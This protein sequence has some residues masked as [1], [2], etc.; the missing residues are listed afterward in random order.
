MFCIY[1]FCIE[2]LTYSAAHKHS[3]TERGKR[4]KEWQQEQTLWDDGW[5]ES[6]GTRTK[7]LYTYG[8]SE[9]VRAWARHVY[10]SKQRGGYRRLQYFCHHLNFVYIHY[11]CIER[12][13]VNEYR[14]CRMIQMSANMCIYIANIQC[15]IEAKG[16]EQQ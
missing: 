16:T 15:F 4:G 10:R 8:V 13:W 12:E 5:R 14:L 9:W 2:Y 6:T 11:F 3:L 7:A 1:F